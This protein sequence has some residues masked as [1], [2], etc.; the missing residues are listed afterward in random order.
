MT[1]Q[2]SENKNFDLLKN[3]IGNIYAPKSYIDCIGRDHKIIYF[4]MKDAGNVE[5]LYENYQSNNVKKLLL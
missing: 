5:I 4:R 1:Y 2:I 3:K